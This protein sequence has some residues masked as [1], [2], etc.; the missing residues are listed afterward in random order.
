MTVGTADRTLDIF[1]S[2]ARRLRPAIVFELA[3]DT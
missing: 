2:F 3:H 1:Q